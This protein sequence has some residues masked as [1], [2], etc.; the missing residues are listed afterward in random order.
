MSK[1]KLIII[2]ILY[3]ADSLNIGPSPTVYNFTTI[4]VVFHNDRAAFYS[5][6]GAVSRGTI[7]P[8]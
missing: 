7:A 4:S 2:T 1:N 8:V 6:N 5:I 3:Y